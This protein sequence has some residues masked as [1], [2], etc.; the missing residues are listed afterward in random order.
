MCLLYLYSKSIKNK[1]KKIST[2]IH[3]IVHC[4]V[5]I[6]FSIIIADVTVGPNP[7]PGVIKVPSSNQTPT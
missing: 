7:V 2:I 6:T 5:T 3:M 4:L 1:K